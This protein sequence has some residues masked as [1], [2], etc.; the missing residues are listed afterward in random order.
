MERSKASGGFGHC[1]KQWLM[2]DEREDGSSKAYVKL[3]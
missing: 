3:D 1:F 2:E